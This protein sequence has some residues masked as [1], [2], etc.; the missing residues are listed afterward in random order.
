[1]LP[2]P[3]KGQ[4]VRTVPRFHVMPLVGLLLAIPLLA[5]GQPK[6]KATQILR[7]AEKALQA[8]DFRAA[9][10]LY[11]AAAAADPE[12]AEASCGLGQVFLA[13]QQYEEAVRS[14]ERCKR[15]VLTN[16]RDLQ[17]Q[18]ASAWGEI[19]REIREIEESLHAI[20]SGRNRS[21]GAD[22]ELRLEERIRELQDIRARDPIRVEM[23]SQVS[24]ALGTAYLNAGLPEKAEWELVTVLRSDPG[25]G[26][27]HNNLAAVYLAM[28]RFQDAAE[29]VRLAE[30]AGVRVNPQMKADI[31]AKYSPGATSM[32]RQE[33]GPAGAAGEPIELE[34]EGRTCAVKGRFVHVKA[35]VT[36]SWGVHDPILRF[37]TEESG[38][39]YS[40]FML[41]AGQN[42]FATILPK[43]KSAKSFTY[44]I[45]VTT[46]DDKTTTTSE[47]PVAI[48]GDATACSEDA[49]DSDEVGNVLI[50]DK[51]RTVAN[52]PPVPRGFS[53]RGTTGDAGAL[54]VGSNKALIYGSLALAGGVAVGV[55]VANQAGG[56]YTGPKPF[57]E[58]PGISLETTTP[59]S[60]STLALS[61]EQMV[62]VQLGVFSTEELPGAR[63]EAELV[64]GPNSAPCIHLRTNQDLPAGRTTSVVLAGPTVPAGAGFCDTRLT[65]GW[66]R[67]TVTNAGGLGG[68][69]TGIPPLGH[70]RIMFNLVE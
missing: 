32:S 7:E 62:S 27:T 68:F 12:S 22:R 3:G 66:V 36:P 24:F 2:P 64:H 39:W 20:R 50:I 63:I 65:L 28:G 5:F 58:A 9:E 16:L 56:A 61:G 25:S 31:S 53:I 17:A 34:H 33:P 41:P 15:D 60:G 13:L 4:I 21:A 67:V 18:Q 38:G 23:P 8:E 11:R 57:S 29:H 35:T 59:P 43:A 55:A 51:P 1:M 52:A 26:D 48:A 30:E 40:T 70:L 6:G 10:R 54:E 14:L 37:R 45:E 46:Y 44:F 19:D 49:E 47:Y 42:D 69:R